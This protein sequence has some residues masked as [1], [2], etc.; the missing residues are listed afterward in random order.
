MHTVLHAA[1]LA[2]AI[3][4]S[5]R[6]EDPTLY[7]TRHD[8][9]TSCIALQYSRSSSGARTKAQR[10]FHSPTHARAAFMRAMPEARHLAEV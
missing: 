1:A 6:T 3:R 9:I 4:I 5:A 7:K 10:A 8:T 2:S